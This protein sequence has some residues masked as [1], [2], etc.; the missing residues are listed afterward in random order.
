MHRFESRVKLTASSH[1]F[2]DLPD[3]P[4]LNFGF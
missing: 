2:L 1:L 3:G 4:V